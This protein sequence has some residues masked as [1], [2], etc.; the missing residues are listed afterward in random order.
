MAQR[1]TKQLNV[2]ELDYDQIKNNLKE[3]LQSQDTLQD[4]NFEGS[5][6]ST[7]IDVL[8]YVTHYNAVNANIGINET[9]L[10]TAQSRGSIVGHAR[11]LSYTPKSATG[12]TAS[13]S[14][15]VNNP[16]NNVLTINKGHRFSSVI[17]N[18]TYT[19]VTTESYNTE[20]A[21]FVDVEI[22]QGET[23]STEYIFDVNTSEKFIIPEV[24]V[25]TST[26]EVNIYDSVGS[27]SYTTFVLAKDI[28]QITATSPVYYLNESFDGRYEI[29]FGDG[30]LGQALVNG[31]LIEIKYLIT[32]GPD[33]NGAVAFSSVDNIEGNSNLT[34]TT[35]A[36]SVGGL[37]K[38]SLKSIKYN[39]P[40]S[41]A[42]QNRAVTPDDYKAVI[43]ENFDNA[44]SIVVWG[45]EDNDPPQYGKAYISIIPKTGET[46]STVDKTT[47]INDIIRPKAVVSITPELVDPEYT[48]IA[49]E[50]FYKRNSS[51]STSSLGQINNSVQQAISSYNDN[52]LRKFDGVL[53]YSTLL[54]AIDTSEK[55]IINSTVR[56][57]MKKRFIPT[58]NETVR[59]ELDFSSS[60][61]ITNS[62]RSIIYRST[63]FTFAG[64]QCTLQD[65]LDTNNER[66]IRVIR[67]S[68]VN[69]ITV[70]SNVGFIDAAAGKIVL[71]GLNVSA[72]TGPYIEITVIPDSNDIA[73]KRNNIVA[74]DT[75]DVVVSGDV[76]K[77]SSGS[78]AGGTNYNS[79]ARHG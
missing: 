16:N 25:D 36:I 47:I 77:V 5:A 64:E 21:F 75:N 10:E 22:T 46:L 61:Y 72:F 20:D 73:P 4:Y 67:G 48:Y 65:Y 66:R 45:G 3:F 9:F 71:T 56:V 60:I 7:L 57:Y 40:L 53:R 18:V 14:V 69:Q 42:A 49:L 79:V 32:E 31:N 70:A 37:P 15:Q 68:G 76:D 26:I 17:D 62:N 28:N 2:S 6:F 39:A 63:T 30:V 41:F 78:A 33:A 34:I 52:Q 44:N 27:T 23:K 59:Y 54:N 12:A 35:N 8:S 11:Q 55:S 50:V 43:L 58:L 74:I 29:T 51:E 1:P 19:F 13:V 38:E 24:N